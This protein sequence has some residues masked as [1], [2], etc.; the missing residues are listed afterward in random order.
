VRDL[1]RERRLRLC[2]AALAPVLLWIGAIAWYN[3]YRF[4]GVTD[5][6]YTESS[7][8]LSAPLNFLGLL[9]S[10]G[11]GL[12]F[13][14][15]L[16]VLGALGLPRLW[17][18]DR[19]L[20]L[21]LLAFLLGLTAVSGA[22]TYWGDEVWGPRYIIP[23]SWTLLVPIAWWADTQARRRV[24]VAVAALG[25]LVQVVGVSAEYNRYQKVVR[26]LTGV[27]VYLDR[28]GVPFE[29]I[30][31]GDDPT[32]W[33]PELSPLLVQTES[34]IS[35]Q[36]IEPLGGSGL[37]VSYAPFEGPTHTVNLSEPRLRIP[38]DFWWAAAPRYKGLAY[39]LALLILALAAAA[40]GGLYL[41]AS[42]RRPR[43]PA[44]AETVP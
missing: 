32:R 21:A 16:V 43:G 1:E 6:G 18:A 4:G 38:L 35:S 14:S 29:E 30:P 19:W 7:L 15:P 3:W 27:P 9:F 23:A 5:F 28:K 13:Y 17:R 10:P 37:T 8:T 26:A 12:I 42:G 41:V 31:Y 22:S 25:L 11:K 36:L 34:L 40:G 39:L 44:A 24:L 20:T 33:I 2:A